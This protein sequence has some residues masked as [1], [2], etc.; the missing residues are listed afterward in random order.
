MAPHRVCTIIAA[1]FLLHN[2]AWTKGTRCQMMRHSGVLFGKNHTLIKFKCVLCKFRVWISFPFPD[3]HW[4]WL[5]VIFFLLKFLFEEKKLFSSFRFY[6]IKQWIGYQI[7][8]VIEC[9]RFQNNYFW[10]H[11][12]FIRC[13]NCEHINFVFIA[14][15]VH[16]HP[17]VNTHSF[18]QCV[19]LGKKRAITLDTAF[20]LQVWRFL[21]A[22]ALISYTSMCSCYCVF[23][24]PLL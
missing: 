1:C 11:F 9:V 12:S 2:I 4:Q 16:L 6:L 22:Y 8:Q 17:N 19:F 15:W 14:I 3:S 5:T 10:H 24:L 7:I 21:Y 20:P 18:I 13:E 23:Y